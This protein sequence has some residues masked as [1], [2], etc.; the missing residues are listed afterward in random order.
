MISNPIRVDEKGRELL[1]H[2]SLAF[3]CAWYY[4]GANQGDVPWHWHEEIELVYLSRG[5]LQCSVGN[6]RFLLCAG[7]ALF[8]NT[9][10]PHAFFEEPGIPYEESDIVFHPRLIYGDVGSIL[11]EKY[12]LP[13]MHC[14][15]MAGFV[16]RRDT[17]WQREASL[18]IKDAITVCKRKPDFYEFTVRSLL[19]NVFTLLLRHNKGHLEQGETRA[20]FLMERVKRMLDYFHSHFQESVSVTQLAAQA[21]ICKREC[22]RDFKKVLGLTPTQYFEQYRL[23]M[24][25]HLLTESSNSIIEI[26]NQCGFQSPSYFTKLFRERYGVTPSAFRLH[27]EPADNIRFPV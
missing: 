14:P 20:S 19:T 21:N 8:I 27:N 10:I 1:T 5:T 17:D 22:Q 23:A 15:S 18:S 9:G 12:M 11:Y 3:P 26:A 4:S 16:F 7:D 13:L 6:Q 24:S 25:V 2:G